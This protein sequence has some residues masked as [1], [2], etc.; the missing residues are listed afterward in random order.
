[1][2]PPTQALVAGIDRTRSTTGPP[3]SGRSPRPRARRGSTRCEI[4]EPERSSLGRTWVT[5]SGGLSTADSPRMLFSLLDTLEAAGLRDV[6]REYLGERPALS[7]N[8]CTVRRVPVDTNA[9]WH[10]DGAFLGNGIRG[11][12]HL[13]RARR[14]RSRRARVSTSSPVAST[15][16]SR[17]ARAARTSTGRSGPISFPRSRDRTP[18][19]RPEFAAGDALLFDDLML[20]CTATDPEMTKSRHAIETWCFAP[21]AYPEGHVPIVW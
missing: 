7:A 11:A 5:N 12:Q 9:G 6:A 10:Q 3:E 2:H 21:S 15:A 14:L 20:H 17:R 16:S 19:V 18:V 8:K 13:A 1:M 4:D